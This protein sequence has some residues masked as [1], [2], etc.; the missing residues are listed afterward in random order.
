MRAWKI[1]D[2]FDKI[3]TENPKVK[4]YVHLVHVCSNCGF[5]TPET[6]PINLM[7]LDI[8]TEIPKTFEVRDGSICDSC[9]E[10]IWHE[11]NEFMNKDIAQ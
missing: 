3:H 4:M 7:E 5:R 10:K 9:N 1:Q 8:P 6:P 2:M 11:I